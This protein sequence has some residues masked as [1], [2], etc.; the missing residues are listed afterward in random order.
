MQKSCHVSS[1]FCAEVLLTFNNSR[2]FLNGEELVGGNI[3]EF[4]DLLC[5]RPRDLYQIHLGR[6]SQAEMEAQVA[7]GHHTRTGMDLVYLCMLSGNDACTGADGCAITLGAEQ[8]EG[9]PI[10]LVAAVV[11]QERWVVVHV[12]DQHI[13]TAIVI[14]VAESATATGESFCHTG[15]ELFRYVLEFAISEIAVDYPRDNK[16]GVQVIFLNLWIHVPVDLEEVS[17]S[18]VVIVHKAG[19]PADILSVHCQPRSKRQ[20]GEGSIPIVVI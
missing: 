11:A 16:L 12:E 15:A 3:G 5:S 4:F 20:I 1:G 9:N 17:P 10:V 6:L 14:I 7:L 8:F 2:A 13:K 19:A 18:I